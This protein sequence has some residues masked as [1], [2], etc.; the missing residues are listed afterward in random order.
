MSMSVT[1]APTYFKE[2]RKFGMLKS[3]RYSYDKDKQR[4]RLPTLH[5]QEIIM[6]VCWALLLKCDCRFLFLHNVYLMFLG[7][8]N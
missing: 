8:D 2:F 3:M 7:H 5:Q 4:P 1:T 6:E